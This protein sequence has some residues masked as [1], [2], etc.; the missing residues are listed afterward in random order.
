[1]TER[2]LNDLFEIERYSVKEWGRKVAD[3]YL[4]DIDAA[5]NRLREDPEILRLELDFS[6]GIYFYRVNKHVL[7]CD[8]ENDSVVVLTVIHTTM[9]L[10][11][12]LRELEPRLVAES[13]MLRAKLRNKGAGN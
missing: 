12:R 2:A 10:P 1:L 6:S 4:G 11:T 3:K 13:Q 9:D 8:Y 5:L 7:V